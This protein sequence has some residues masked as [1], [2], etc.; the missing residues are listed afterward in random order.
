MINDDE[1]ITY[2]QFILERFV[3][4]TRKIFDNKTFTPTIR[5]HIRKQLDDIVFDIVYYLFGKCQ[6]QEVMICTPKRWI[7]WFKEKRLG[8]KWMRWI[9]RRFPPRYKFHYY[10]VKKYTMFPDLDLP[11]DF[12]KKIELIFYEWE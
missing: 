9:I 7:D 1:F 12:E 4:Q 3:I 11:Y 6:N 10:N 2:K 5:T 8:K